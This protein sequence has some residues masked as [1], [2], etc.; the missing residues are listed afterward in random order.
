[1]ILRFFLSKEGIFEKKKFCFVLK[2]R[3]MA[4]KIASRGNQAD[5]FENIFLGYK[6]IRKV[7]WSQ[8]HNINFVIK[9][10]P[11][12]C[13]VIHVDPIYFIGLAPEAIYFYFRFFYKPILFFLYITYNISLLDTYFLDV[14]TTT[15]IF[16]SKLV[17]ESIL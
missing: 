16:I 6:S 9:E 8:S 17:I 5:S 12:V 2:D 4:W 14:R 3:E 11:S 1:M 15:D 10:C 13:I 7:S